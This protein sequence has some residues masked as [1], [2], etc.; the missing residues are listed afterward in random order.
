MI[1]IRLYNNNNNNN[2]IVR[3]ITIIIYN[4]M[5]YEAY[6]IYNWKVLTNS[7]LPHHY[8]VH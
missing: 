3:I 8:G 4:Y 5:T 6:V 2:N 1:T 7:C